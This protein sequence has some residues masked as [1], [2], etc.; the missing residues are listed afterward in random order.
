MMLFKSLL[1][2]LALAAAGAVLAHPGQ[3][4]QLQQVNRHLEQAPTGQELYVQRGII[5]SEGG[6]YD[7]AMADF[8]HAR[9]LGPP[10]LVAFQLGVLC[11]RME[12]YER[13]V[14]YLNAYLE[15]FP[16]YAPA[17][18]YLARIARDTGDYDL[19]VAR[20]ETYFRL[21]ESPNPGHY[22]A[23]A[24][25]LAETGRYEQ[26][27]AIIDQGQAS[28]GII[29]QLQRAAVAL[30]VQRKQPEQG[31][32]RLLTLQEML[33]S[34]PA[35]RVDMADLLIMVG[36]PDDATAMA[37]AAQAELMGLRPTPAR[38]ALQQRATA[39]LSGLQVESLPAGTAVD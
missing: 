20:L 37:E 3:H 12:A 11:Y 15:Q 32:Q 36:R 16:N 22:L 5:Y 19:A 1:A 4:D 13:A 8:Q 39:L 29:P 17:Y 30:E 34:S 38:I 28:L 7:E 25:M 10:V 18:D 9:T 23:A 26:A 31:L 33:G 24:N 14:S 21:H 27:L 6:Q 2:C 35:W